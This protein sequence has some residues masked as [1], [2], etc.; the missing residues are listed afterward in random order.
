MTIPPQYIM[1][2]LDGQF[3]CEVILPPAC[4]ISSAKGRPYPKKSYAK[5]SAAFEA[6]VQLRK[7]GE[8]DERLL[9]IHVKQTHAMANAMLAL[10]L[11][12]SNKYTRLIKPRQWEQTRGV[13][14]DELF[15]TILDIDGEME[16]PHQPLGLLTRKRLPDLLSF[17]LWL[18]TGQLVNAQVATCENV[19]PLDELLLGQLTE[20][21][22][23]MYLDVF[24][25]VY[26][27]DVTKMDYWVA[28]LR[29]NLSESKASPLALIDWEVLIAVLNQH[30]Y[31]WTRDTPNDFLLDKFFVDPYDGG[32]RGFSTHIHPTLKPQDPVPPDA[33]KFKPAKHRTVV[34]YSCSLYRHSAGRKAFMASMDPNQPVVVAE[35]VQLR[36]NY[37]AEPQVSDKALSERLTEYLC[38][39]N[40]RISTVRPMQRAHEND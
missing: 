19:L 28:P 37:L 36:R 39:Q 20:F 2:A 35:A 23:R 34:E 31:R 15:L 7:I 18:N 33:H 16:R 1:S 6:C 3:V 9:P 26:E 27:R 12:Q 5:R 8:L 13:A 22:F 21:T 10:S 24:N 17:P 29:P 4:P 32:R 38:P 14:P 40:F 30:E 11:K 25:K